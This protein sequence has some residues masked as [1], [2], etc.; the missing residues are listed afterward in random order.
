MR[1]VL[2]APRARPE[3]LIQV[4]RDREPAPG[5]AAL[6]DSV[7]VARAC[8]GDRTALRHLHD[9]HRPTAYR[10]ARAFS[11]LDADDVEDVLQEAFVRAFRS[12]AKLKDPGRFGPW[13]LVIAR[14]RALSRLARRRAGAALADELSK[15]AERAEEPPFEPPEAEAGAEIEVVRRVIA[16]LPEG[17]EKE[18]VRLFYLEGELTAREI[19]ER[20]GVGKSAITMRL[21]R[22]RA[23]VKRRVLA[24]VARLRGDGS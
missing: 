12:L 8:E 1:Q 16:E 18:T 15:E 3:Y 21:E 17:P 22:F 5:E 10:L 2:E 11:D 13:L 6:D 23:K 24:E 9:R 7:L 4:T 20:L 14:N 19:A